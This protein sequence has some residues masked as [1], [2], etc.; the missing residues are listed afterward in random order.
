[1]SKSL[2]FLRFIGVLLCFANVGVVLYA[3]ALVSWL[4]KQHFRA[5]FD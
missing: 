2:A 3:V 4:N 5:T 1:M